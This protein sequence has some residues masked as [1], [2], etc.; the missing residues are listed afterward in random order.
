MIHY[1]KNIEQIN[2]DFS[3]NVLFNTDEIKKIHLKEYIS[4]FAKSS[5][6]LFEPLLNKDYFKQ[7]ILDSYGTLSWPNEVEFCPDV[8]YKMATNPEN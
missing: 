7:V 3:V 1:I 5:P 8:L 2:E 4:K 6:K